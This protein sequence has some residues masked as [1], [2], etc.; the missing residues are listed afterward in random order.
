MLITRAQ[1]SSASST[2]GYDYSKAESLTRNVMLFRILP[3]LTAWDR[4]EL[5]TD[6][7]TNMSIFDA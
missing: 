5:T 2:S 7:S 3:Q 1:S 6:G 4:P